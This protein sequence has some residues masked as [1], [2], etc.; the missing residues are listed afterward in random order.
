MNHERL[1][2]FLNIAKAE[3]G[4]LIRYICIGFSSLALTSFLYFLLS[5]IFFPHRSHTL[6]YIA[7]VVFVSWLNYEAN[8][9][10]TFGQKRSLVSMRR[11]ITV[12]IIATMMNAVLF[13]TGY[14]ILHLW[15]MLVIVVDC[16]IVSLFTFSSHRLFTFHEKPWQYFK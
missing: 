8:R 6:S 13:W 16:G 1:T 5:T 2:Y 7:V 15:D 9:Y 3:R 14:E 4:R 11:F 12:A 10:F